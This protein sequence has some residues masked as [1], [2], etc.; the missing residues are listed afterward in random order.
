[1][2]GIPGKIAFVGYYTGPDE[3]PD[4]FT[5]TARG[6]EGTDITPDPMVRSPTQTGLRTAEGSPSSTAR[7]VGRHP[8]R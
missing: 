5:F 7:R 1:M 3:Q 6:T 8:S 4:I 2:L